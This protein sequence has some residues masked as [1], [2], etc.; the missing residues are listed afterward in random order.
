MS[1]PVPR[2]KVRLLVAGHNPVTKSS[3]AGRV[4]EYVSLQN[5]SDSV[6]AMRMITDAYEMGEP[7]DI[8]VLDAALSAGDDVDVVRYARTLEGSQAELGFK[9]SKIFFVARSEDPHTSPLADEVSNNA[10]E[11]I[12]EEIKK[13]ANQFKAF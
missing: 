2:S 12:V 5:A 9:S 11:R 4:G 7:F 1:T 3:I 10:I 13:I 8:L 6:G